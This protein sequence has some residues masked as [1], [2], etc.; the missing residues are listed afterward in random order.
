MVSKG[1]IPSFLLTSLLFYQLSKLIIIF[2]PG[3]PPQTSLF[4]TNYRYQ[5][6]HHS[7]MFL[8]EANHTIHLGHF[9]RVLINKLFIKRNPTLPLSRMPLAEVNYQT[10]PD[11]PSRMPLAEANHQSQP[12]NPSRMS[13]AKAN[14][15]IATQQSL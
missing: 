1:I 15:S 9:S 6:N 5:P 2:K 14:Q 8:A 10:Q 4:E 12:C 13:L 3:H 11:N 7:R